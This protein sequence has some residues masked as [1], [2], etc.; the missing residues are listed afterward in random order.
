MTQMKKYTNDSG[1]IYD[2]KGYIGKFDNYGN[3]V[4]DKKSFHIDSYG[5]VLDNSSNTSVGKIEGAINLYRQNT[6]KHLNQIHLLLQMP[7]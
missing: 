1:R 2:D 5:N 6:K 7:S 3:F 4:T